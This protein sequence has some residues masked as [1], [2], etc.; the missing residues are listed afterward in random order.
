LKNFINELEH[1]PSIEEIEEF[2]V[3]KSDSW[4]DEYDEMED[5]GCIEIYDYK[6]KRYYIAEWQPGSERGSIGKEIIKKEDIE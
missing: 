5:A 2:G 4:V 3:F 1:Q 6:N